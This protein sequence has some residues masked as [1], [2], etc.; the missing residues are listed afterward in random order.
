MWCF[1]LKSY[2]YLFI[3]FTSRK[4]NLKKSM[5]LTLIRYMKNRMDG[6]AIDRHYIAVQTCISPSPLLFQA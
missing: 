1:L 6:P 2:F 4:I 5:Y 3:G